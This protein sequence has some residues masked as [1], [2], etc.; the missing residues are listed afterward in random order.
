M[1]PRELNLVRVNDGFYSQCGTASPSVTS[2]TIDRRAYQLLEVPGTG[3]NSGA[4]HPFDAWR[5]AYGARQLFD[6]WSALKMANP[7]LNLLMRFSKMILSSYNMHSFA[8]TH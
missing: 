3:T 1:F 8:N 6:G 2:N 4:W 7:T 5:V